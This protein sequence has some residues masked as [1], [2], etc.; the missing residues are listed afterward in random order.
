MKKIVIIGGA[1]TVGTILTKGLLKD[2]EVTVLD[3]KKNETLDVPFIKVDATSLDDLLLLVPEADVLINLLNTDT[4]H[5]IE[6]V[7]TFEQMT[8]TFFK[9]TYYILHTAR[10]KNIPKVIFASTNHVTDAYE[11]EGRSL[12][13]REITIEDKP[14]SRGLYGVLKYASEQIGQLFSIEEN[15]SVINIRIGS[16]PKGVTKQ[17]IE[18]ND[19]LKK[20]LLSH[21]DLIRL[22]TAA[23]ET[24]RSF[25]TYYGVSDN[26]GKPWD[27]ANAKSELGFESH[28]D[29]TDIL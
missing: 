15:I 14:S 28:E 12:L 19:R 17:T 9:A 20:T 22:F 26:P 29:T 3:H 16:V 2:Y 11:E 13:G 23:V 7:Q 10:K 8:T 25:G 21:T 27:M 1:G 18:E 24:D 5:A 4:S 6:D